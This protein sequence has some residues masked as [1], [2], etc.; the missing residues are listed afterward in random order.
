MC[1]I[2][3]GTMRSVGVGTHTLG[4]APIIACPLPCMHRCDSVGRGLICKATVDM[5]TLITRRGVAV[6]REAVQARLVALLTVLLD[7]VQRIG[8]LLQDQP[9]ALM[10]VSQE[11]LAKVICFGDSW[12][13]CP[14][15]SELW[16]SGI[17]GG[18]LLICLLVTWGL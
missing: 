5:L 18:H 3:A 11:A 13:G 4:L 1:C 10:K 6:H 15:G 12:L 8:V 14:G 16:G 2:G 7:E 9:E 17:G